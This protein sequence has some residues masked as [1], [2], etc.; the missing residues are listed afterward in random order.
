MNH[1]LKSQ[2]YLTAI[3]DWYS[4]YVLKH[5]DIYLKDY[6]YPEEARI[7]IREY[8]DFYNNERPHQNLGYKTPGQVY[9]EKETR[10]FRP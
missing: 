2:L 9:Y 1:K 7:G 5:E 3:T 4:R 8:I 6:R 10:S